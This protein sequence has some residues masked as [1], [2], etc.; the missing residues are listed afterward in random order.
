M[1]IQ[2]LVSKKVIHNKYGEG[3]ITDVKETIVTVDFGKNGLKNFRYPTGFEFLNFI[4]DDEL[5]RSILLERDEAIMKKKK[6]LTIKKELARNNV[7]NNKKTETVDELING[8]MF[9]T[10]HEVLNKC[11]GFNYLKYRKAYKSVDE[12]YAVWFPNIARKVNDEYI[13]TDKSLGWINIMQNGGKEIIQMDHPIIPTA[14][15]DQIDKKKRLVFIAKDEGYE[16]IGVYD[17]PVRI[18]G[19]YR[20]DKISDRFKCT[21][22]E[23]L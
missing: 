22:M 13:S 8:H 9:G 1:E 3:Y 15:P 12:S 2:S 10:H 11:F 5:T 7:S 4:D 16:F 23:V 14:D 6:E 18:K 17:I 21:T 20:Y 19:G